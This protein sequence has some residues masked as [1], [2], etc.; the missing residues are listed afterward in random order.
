M[1]KEKGKRDGR[2]REEKEGRTRKRTRNEDD[3]EAAK[4]AYCHEVTSPTFKK[5]FN[6]EIVS[7]GCLG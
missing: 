7:L 1:E 5:I 4:Q 2:G 3:D 6:F